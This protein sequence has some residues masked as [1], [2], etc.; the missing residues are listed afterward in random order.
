MTIEEALRLGAE[1]LSERSDTARL[2]SECLLT[3]S[4]NV[5]RSHLYAWPQ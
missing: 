3:H 1:K 2:D 5:Q 4:L